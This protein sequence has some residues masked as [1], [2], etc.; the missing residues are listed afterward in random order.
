MTAMAAYLQSFQDQ[1]AVFTESWAQ[2]LLKAGVPQDAAFVAIW[3]FIFL[4]VYFCLLS[5]RAAVRIIPTGAKR[6]LVLLLGQTNAGKSALFF[7]LH[8]EECKT[9]SSLKPNQ[10]AV[11]VDGLKVDMIDYPGHNRMRNFAHELVDRAKCVVYMIDASDKPRFRDV[12]ENLYELFTLKSINTFRT[13]ILLVCNKSDLPNARVVPVVQED[14]ER[15]IER[16]RVSRGATL[17]GQDEVDNFLGI[18]GEAFKMDHA[19]CV[20]DFCEASVI[21]G[22]TED[23]TCWIRSQF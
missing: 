20:V 21:N 7:L 13:P 22:K 14:L 10:D 4:G 17:E 18:D 6:D 1:A 23:I 12:A 8:G 9:V 15:E 3:F 11:Y 2:P 19:P 5:V 16:L